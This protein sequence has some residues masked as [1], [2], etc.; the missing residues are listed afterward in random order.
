ML[1]QKIKELPKSA[2]V[3]QYFD[4]KN[5]LLYIGKAKNLSNRVKSYFQF[6]PELKPS[7]TLSARIH[8][9]ISE[10]KY[11]EYIIVN[12]EHDALILENSLIKQLK[13]KYNILLRDDKTYPYIYFDENENYPRFE[14][15][16]KIVAKKGIKYFGPFSVGSFEILD[17]LYDIFPLVQ[18]K[19]CLNSKKA[20]LFYQIKKCLAPCEGKITPLEYMDIVKK[21]Q[22]LITNKKE[23]IRLLEEKM[24]ALSQQL[25]FEEA[26]VIR[27]RIEKIKKVVLSSDIDLAKIENF[28]IF[29]IE[30]QESKAIVVK[31]FLRDGKII[32]SS[33]EILNIDEKFDISECYKQLLLNFYTKEIPLTSTKVI[34]A[35]EFEDLEAIEELLSERFGKKISITV[36]KIGDKKKVLDL[37]IKNAQ[38]LLKIEN[39]VKPSTILHE[40]QE[41]FKL[42]NIPNKIEIFDCS[43]LSFEA[44]VGGMVVCEYE[45]FKKDDYKRYSLNG[46]DEYSQMKELLSRRALKFAENPP[47]D[48]WIID[49]GKAQLNLALD[50]IQ[51]SGSNIDV[52][53]I[54]K[55]KLDFKAH[56]A[57]GS[58]KDIIYTEHDRFELLPTDKRLQ[59]IQKLRDEAHRFAIS[60]HRAKKAKQDREIS[61]L[62]ISGIGEAKLKK[63]IDFFGSFENIKKSNIDELSKVIDLNSAKKVVDFFGN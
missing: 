10:T 57:K 19:S 44:I 9:M 24:F 51:S 46:L 45:E 53:S 63:L 40:I 15:T 42:Q 30:V 22:N 21:A 49:G 28:D 56:R 27:D 1:K 2:G 54:S 37:C 61:L 47:P 11:L 55:E 39:R 36:P 8:K 26:L 29:V 48:L 38:E 34:V 23:L 17:A 59:F 3:Y 12:S 52:I 25:R 31:T 43:H 60:F 50:I 7:P 16:R 41:L 32:S 62:K 13:P 6:T 58:A 5:H 18:K 20:C 4:E 33:K 14:I 35:F